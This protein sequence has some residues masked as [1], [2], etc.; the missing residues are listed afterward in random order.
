MHSF[1]ANQLISLKS[2]CSAQGKATQLLLAD[3]ARMQ[4]MAVA[5]N[6]LPQLGRDVFA[7]HGAV[8]PFRL[9]PVERTA[10]LSAARLRAPAGVA[11]AVGSNRGLPSRAA[12]ALAC[13]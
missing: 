6:S 4:V 3:P 1:R 2:E 5:L 9:A 10:D 8:P 7:R 13:A 11:T 12:A